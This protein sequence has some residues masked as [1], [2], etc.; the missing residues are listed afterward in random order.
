MKKAEIFSTLGHSVGL[1]IHFLLNANIISLCLFCLLSLVP[2]ISFG[3]AGYLNK[4][5]AFI[6]GQI[7]WILIA[8]FGVINNI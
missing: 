2:P 8:I 4:D 3:I 7:G 1:G 6:V 5:R